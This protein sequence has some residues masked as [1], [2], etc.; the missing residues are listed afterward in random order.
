MPIAAI[1]D[2]DIVQE[3]AEAGDEASARFLAAAAGCAEPL[4]G[5]EGDEVAAWFAT[6]QEADAWLLDML[7]DEEVES[8][9]GETGVVLHPS[10]ARTPR[11][12]LGT[13]WVA[14]DDGQ[15]AWVDVET[16]I[17]PDD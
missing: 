17:E 14:W 3:W 6:P 2:R 11:P 16:L 1:V 4:F 13:V 5:V 15:E 8:P 7:V 9:E 10:R 12:A